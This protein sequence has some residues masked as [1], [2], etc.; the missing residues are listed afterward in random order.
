MRKMY[1]GALC[2]AL[3]LA[4]CEVR[5][6]NLSEPFS[7]P[8][9][10]PFELSAS[11]DATKTTIDGSWHM[12]WE[13]GDKIYA[14]TTDKEWGKDY[15]NDH[16]GSS[17]AEFILSAG[18]FSTSAEITDGTHTFNFLYGRSDQ[19]SYHRGGKTT[20]K[21]SAE[22][23][24]DCANPTAHLKQNDALVGQLASLT[25]PADKQTVTMKHLFSLM[26]VT[27]INQTGSDITVDSFEMTVPGVGLAGIANV[28][29][30]E[31]PSIS[32]ETSGKS[33]SILVNLEGGSISA[34]ASLPVYFVFSPISGYSGKISF[35]VTD[36]SGST[37]T[38]STAV[39]NL[40]FEAGKYN[41]ASFTLKDE[42]SYPDILAATDEIHST[43]LAATTNTYTPFYDVSKSSVAKYDGNTAK[44]TKDSDIIQMRASD[45]CGIVSTMSGG[46]VKSVTVDWNDAT[47]S[48]R[49][50][51]VYGSNT[52]YLGSVDL[53]SAATQGTKI[54]SIVY[55]TSTTLN[56]SRTFRYIGIRSLSGSL[57]LNSI[58]ITW[59]T[60]PAEAAQPIVGLGWLE[61]PANVNTSTIQ[62]TTTSSLSNLYSIAHFAQM[63]GSEQRNYS[64]LYDPEMY[65]SYWVAYPLCEDHLG[66]GRK[67]SWGYDPDVP[68]AYQTDLRDGAYLV[69]VGSTNSVGY[70][71]ALNKYSRGHQIPNADRNGVDEMMAQTYYSTNITPQI[72][73]GF[74]GG[75]WEKLEENVRSCISGNDTLYV[76]SGAAFKTLPDGTESITWITS[77]RDG[78]SLP[79]PNYYWKALLK[80]KIS[81]GDIISASTIGV[82]MPHEYLA[83][84]TYTEYVTS[85]NDIEALT[86]FDLFPGLPD[87]IEETVEGNSNWTT[88][89]NF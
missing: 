87:G 82:W 77:G 34:G 26:K 21:L 86:G 55:G 20:Y 19:K 84:H 27:L 10:I 2:A 65:S 3:A 11:V 36:E 23:N 7:G 17:I 62:A 56:V 39:K 45:Q 31:T 51:D 4:G 41:T 14:V 60:E 35:C 48:G 74:N 42:D 44:K 18:K 88:F 16:S 5:D 75:I 73:N 8:K 58:S 63:G 53:Y 13:E 89:K 57:Y 67:S 28:T 71:D 6:I 80:V 29:F 40:T 54:G 78:K 68:K 70:Q 43:D 33:N 32:I 66:S 61:L 85:V 79:L 64:L 38:K 9:S 81:G 59:G 22:Q 83:G 24:Q 46:Y 1:L 25:T 49:T 15:A 69:N 12:A 52:P 37:Y 50:I 47:S 72:Q 30:G 76:V